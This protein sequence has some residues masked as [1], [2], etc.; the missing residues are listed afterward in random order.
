MFTHPPEDEKKYKICKKC[1]HRQLGKISPPFWSTFAIRLSIVPYRRYYISEYFLVFVFFFLAF[2]L[3]FFFPF[4][5]FCSFFVFSF[6]V[7]GSLACVCCLWY[8]VRRH[9]IT[10]TTAL[11]CK[12]SC[13]I[14]LIS[15]MR[16]SV[17]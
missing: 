15:G 2:S 16:E 5:F 4:L 8:P 12:I 17:S 9:G 14:S 7:S 6:N 1:C 13:V 10:P 11:R 3:C